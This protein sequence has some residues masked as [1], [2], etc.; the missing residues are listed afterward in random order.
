[1]SLIIYLTETNSH[2]L[3]EYVIGAKLVQNKSFSY[4]C[5]VAVG[6]GL[7]KSLFES[8]Q[9]NRYAFAWFTSR[10]EYKRKM[11]GVKS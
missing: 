11:S 7:Y 5:N 9:E 2:N 6:I 8:L 4:T 10:V 1:M 3:L